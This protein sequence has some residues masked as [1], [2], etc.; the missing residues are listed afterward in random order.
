MKARVLGDLT[1]QRFLRNYWQRKP[2]FV[3][4]A[5]REMASCFEPALLF[6]LALREDVESRLVLRERGRWRVEHGPFRRADLKRL[7]SRG[8]SLLVQGADMHLDAARALM[9]RFDFVPYARHDDLMVS[10][11][12]EGGGVGPHFDSYD[13]FLL[14][15]RGARRWRI[16]A[17]P[18]LTLVEGAPLRILE[19]F[20]PEREL[21]VE[22]GDLLYLPPRYAHEGVALSESITCSIG[23]RAPSAEELVG[24]FLQWL[25]DA[26]SSSGRYC[27]PGLALQRHPAQISTAMVRRIESMLRAIRWGRAEVERFVGAQL[28]EPKSQIWFEPPRPALPFARFL[29]HAQR[30][31]VRLALKS[32]MLF[33]DRHFF[34]NGDYVRA[35]SGDCSALVALADARR[36][37]PWTDPSPQAARQ[38]YAW[39]RQGYVE[40]L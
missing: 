15:A 38:V 3:K 6:D 20:R 23:F 12:P 10:L 36:L 29:Q 40:L 30:R 17:Q 8:W 25:P 18:D 24:S 16:G 5:L 32:R 31:G 27:D 13:V 9:D 26:L 2:L 22:P 11:A 19:Q 4:N 34:I 14:Q 33:R 1:P 7:P 37:A 35:R 28:T 39:Y 21:T